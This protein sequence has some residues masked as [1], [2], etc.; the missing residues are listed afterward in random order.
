MRPRLLEQRLPARAG[1]QPDHLELVAA[2]DHVESLG[3]D[4]ARGPDDHDPA[5]P[6]ESR[7]APCIKGELGLAGRPV[8]L[9]MRFGIFYEHQN[10]RPWA[11]ERSEHTLLHNALAQVEL[12]DR[13]G[14]D[15]V[16]EV[17]HHFLEEYSHSSAPEVFLAAAAA[18]TKRI[19]LGHGIVQ[20]PPG[21]EPSRARGGA[22]RH[23]RP[24]LGR[25]A[26][27]RHRRVQLRGRARRLPRRSRCRSARCGRTRSTRSRA[28]S[29]RSRSPA[30]TASSSACPRATWSRSRCSGRIRRCGWP[31]AGARRSSSPPATGSG[32]C[33]SR[34]WSPRTPA[35]G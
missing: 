12:A 17:E 30:G 33:R 8:R 16:W 25:P 24:D 19:R 13:V 15:Y 28:C 29:W 23:A 22:R 2:L 14:F 10:P 34:S 11:G 26:R 7:R 20:I 6:D 3:S 32:R 1:R 35:S 27:V 9:A 21:R 4:R 31:A 5:H 18:R